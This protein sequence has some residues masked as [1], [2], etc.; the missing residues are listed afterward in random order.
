MEAEYS[1]LLSLAALSHICRSKQSAEQESVKHPWMCREEFL[2]LEM[3]AGR[4]CSCKS[5]KC[6]LNFV[7]QGDCNAVFYSCQLQC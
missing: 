4:P 5:L 6:V 1:W 7:E 3:N 2:C